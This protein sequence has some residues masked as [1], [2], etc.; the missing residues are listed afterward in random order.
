MTLHKP[1]HPALTIEALV[2]W[3]RT[4]PAE[5]TYIWSDPVFCAV[6]QYLADHGSS[7][8]AVNYSEIP[9]YYEIAAEK[10]WTFGAALERAEKLLALP[11]PKQ[12]FT[13]T[14][15]YTMAHTPEF[16]AAVTTEFQEPLALPA[17]E[18]KPLPLP[19]LELMALPAPAP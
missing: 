2:T 4:Q 10:P 17:P 7:W 8:G 12:P 14:E 13:V 5:K 19:E 15:S 9:G 18:P 1:E 16:E 6:G 11:T 3:L